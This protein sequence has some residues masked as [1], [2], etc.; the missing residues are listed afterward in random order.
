M[1]FHRN[2][3]DHLIGIRCPSNQCNKYYVTPF[4]KD[5]ICQIEEHNHRYQEQQHIPPT[6]LAHLLSDVP[7]TSSLPD[8]SMKSSQCPGIEGRKAPGHLE[9]R[10]VSHKC[11]NSLCAPCCRILASRTC[12]YHS[13]KGSKGTAASPAL[14]LEKPTEILEVQRVIHSLPQ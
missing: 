9:H 3:C 14:A 1:Y 12:F 6:S 5:V 7:I 10:S 8:V 13:P 4:L 11:T 2:G